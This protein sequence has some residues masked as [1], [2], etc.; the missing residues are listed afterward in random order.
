MLNVLIFLV[1]AGIMFYMAFRSVQLRRRLEILWGG[2]FFGQRQFNE[3]IS[4]G[5]L[6]QFTPAGSLYPPAQF[7]KALQIGQME[8]DN[9]GKGGCRI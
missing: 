7:L 4:A 6:P 8:A 1:G 3:R 2:H 9:M 5:D